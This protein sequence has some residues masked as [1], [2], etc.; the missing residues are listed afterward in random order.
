ML[1]HSLNFWKKKIDSE[2]LKPKEASIAIC[3]YMF[4]K[5]TK[6]LQIW[7][8]NHLNDVNLK[9]ILELIIHNNIL[10]HNLEVNH[11]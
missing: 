5:N 1:F 6:I 4:V 3:N 9:M 10:N 2:V 11:R 7:I 8:F